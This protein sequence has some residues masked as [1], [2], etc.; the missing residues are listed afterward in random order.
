VPVIVFGLLL[1]RTLG[2]GLARLRD[3]GNAYRVLARREDTGDDS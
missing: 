3:R 2:S 1:D